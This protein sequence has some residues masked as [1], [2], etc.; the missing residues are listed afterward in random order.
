MG[1]D[2][3]RIQSVMFTDPTGRFDDREGPVVWAV[4]VEE[5]GFEVRAGRFC[6]SCPRAPRPYR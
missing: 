6:G 1:A 4:T 3:G 5:N 2:P